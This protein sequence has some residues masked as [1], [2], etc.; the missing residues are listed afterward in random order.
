[1]LTEKASVALFY[2]L[3]YKDRKPYYYYLAQKLN[4]RKPVG[5]LDLPCSCHPLSLQH[6]S[7]QF[8]TDLLLPGSLL[9]IF[10]ILSF[11]TFSPTRCTSLF[12]TFSRSPFWARIKQ[13][14]TGKSTCS[15]KTRRSQ[16]QPGSTRTVGI[17]SFLEHQFPQGRITS[18]LK[19][20]VRM[21]CG[22]NTKL[23]AQSSPRGRQLVFWAISSKSAHDHKSLHRLVHHRS[24]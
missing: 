20:G 9:Q 13:Q 15:L 3:K 12:V 1:M 11:W 17:F 14:D 23:L 8:F 6:T 2:I 7:P 16:Y 24:P 10:L 21:K 4:T 22:I 18:T 5:K 19:N